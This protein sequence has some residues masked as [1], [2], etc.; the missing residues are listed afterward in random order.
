MPRPAAAKALALI[1]ACAAPVLPGAADVQL[2]QPPD[3]P[4]RGWAP[5]DPEGPIQDLLSH[6]LFQSPAVA[7]ASH[8][9]RTS[10][11]GPFVSVS[12]Y[13]T[14]CIVGRE[15]HRVIM[16][17]EIADYY[18][19]HHMCDYVNGSFAD[20]RFS[21]GKYWMLPLEWKDFPVMRQSYHVEFPTT[22]W[23]LP[24]EARTVHWVR[25]PLKQLVSAYRYNM[26]QSMESEW[27]EMYLVTEAKCGWCDILS[28]HIIFELCNFTCSYQGLLNSLPPEAGVLV[29][30]VH[31]S[32]VLQTMVWNVERWANNPDVLFLSNEH[33][34]L[35]FNGTM[36][37]LLD[38]AGFKSPGLMDKLQQL[39]V[40]VHPTR[41]STAGLYNNT[42]LL[43][44]LGALPSLAKPLAAL[45][46]VLAAIYGR[47][48]RDYGCPVPA[49]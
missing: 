22:T 14:G 31:Q 47:Q 24:P 2:Q 10:A 8:L 19:N 30:A 25:D 18:A 32:A 1:A 9:P 35:D 44:Q 17:Y 4:A 36:R 39:D 37:C 33:L 28:H 43:R 26:K 16:G 6:R 40:R 29:E 5:G 21:A 34:S 15:L 42:E 46:A 23:S 45:R 12:Y 13:K 41:H 38:F 48:A 7:V 3:C 49:L 20:D 27:P 11:S